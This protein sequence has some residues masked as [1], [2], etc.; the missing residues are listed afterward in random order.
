MCKRDDIFELQWNFYLPSLWSC[1]CSL[2]SSTL[3]VSWAAPTLSSSAAVVSWA[4]AAMPDSAGVQDLCVVPSSVC[5]CVANKWSL[6]DVLV[7]DWGGC[8]SDPSALTLL[9]VI[10]PGAILSPVFFLFE[11][12]PLGLGVNPGGYCGKKQVSYRW[13]MN[14]Y[15]ADMWSRNYLI[16]RNKNLVMLMPYHLQNSSLETLLINLGKTN[17]CIYLCC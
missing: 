8:T 13:K 7:C 15:Y 5:P 11:A 4:G 6:F 1:S 14:S 10:D 2:S 12:R 9:L 16:L 3:V 17:L